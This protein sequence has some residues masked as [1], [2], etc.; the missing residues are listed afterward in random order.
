VLRIAGGE[1]WDKSHSQNAAG[2]FYSK[3]LLLAFNSLEKG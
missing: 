3:K 2:I 1:V